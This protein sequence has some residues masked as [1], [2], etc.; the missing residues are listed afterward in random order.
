VIGT[1][2]VPALDVK[3]LSVSY[4]GVPA[5][6]GVSFSVAP[7]EVV[8]L[9]GANGAGKSSVLRAISGLVRSS[10]EVRLYGTRIDGQPSHR[11]VQAGVGHVPEGRRLFPAM[12]TRENLELGAY[13]R[14]GSKGG[15]LADVERRFPILGTRARQ[16]AGKLSGGEQQMLAIGRALMASP[17]LLML[18]EP[19]IGLGPLVVRQIE[20]MIAATARED[21]VGVVLVEQ[22]ARLALS[23]STRAYVLELGRIVLS[24]ASAQLLNDDRVRSAYLAY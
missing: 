22:N 10:G 1:A 5:V 15:Q 4:G 6:R 12:T 11:I 2:A 17:R 23:V 16:L 20:T 3:D 9:I 13:V 21:R 24:G 18:D 14:K 7:G 19:S 8:A